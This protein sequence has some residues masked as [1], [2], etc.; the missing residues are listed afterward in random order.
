MK[1]CEDITGFPN[2]GNSCYLDCVLFCLFA[3]PNAFIDKH[4][5]KSRKSF[6]ECNGGGQNIIKDFQKVFKKIIDS[7]QS[8][9]GDIESCQPLK[10]LINKYRKLCTILTIYPNFGNAHQHEALEF[11]QFLI[12]PF[13]LN[14]MKNVGNHLEFEK[15]YGVASSK[16]NIQ[17][18][19]WF[20]HIDKKSSIIYFVD[21]DS[22]KKPDKSIK[23][24]INKKEIVHN[25]EGTKY[26]KCI[27]NTSE[28]RQHFVKFSN[29]FIVAIDRINPFDGSVLHSKIKIDTHVT[30]D[31]HIDAIIIHVGDS[32]SSGHYICFKK[33]DNGWL[34]YD[35]LSPTVKIFKSWNEVL[36]YR[37]NIVEKHGVLF[38][39]TR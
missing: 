10:S 15:R 33:C 18:N 16:K 26:K 21:H 11:L 3:T 32:D 25:L 22:F 9:S 27:V 38:F 24:F 2:I 8:N 23:R 4:I 34:F 31:L 13:G 12:T 14:G 37:K 17:W 39:Y 1:H 35:D 19:E 30:P 20:K 6:I 7:F 29:L 36:K 28:E 5:I